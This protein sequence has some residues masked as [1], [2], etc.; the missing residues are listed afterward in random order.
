MS[1]VNLFESISSF[2]AKYLEINKKDNFQKKKKFENV[3]RQLTLLEAKTQ[4]EANLWKTSALNQNFFQHQFVSDSKTLKRRANFIKN[5]GSILRAT[6]EVCRMV[7][8]VFLGIGV[9]NLGSLGILVALGSSGIALNVA[10]IKIRLAF[11]IGL[12]ASGIFSGV[13]YY[14]IHQAASLLSHNKVIR[15]SRSLN[16]ENFNNFLKRFVEKEGDVLSQEKKEDRQLHDLYL[17]FKHSAKEISRHI[18]N[19]RS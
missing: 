3:N 14:V 19:R 6:A 15:Q 17:N 12:V 11:A 5:M 13:S 1:K 16:S 18:L 7:A 2:H 4:E 10:A 8:L 9:L